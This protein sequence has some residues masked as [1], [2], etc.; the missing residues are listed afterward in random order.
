MLAEMIELEN[1]GEDWLTKMSRMS[2]FKVRKV[3]RHV[4][5]MVAGAA[6]RTCSRNNLA[7]A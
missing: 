3:R 5:V 2:L 7:D 4:V 1:N 6:I